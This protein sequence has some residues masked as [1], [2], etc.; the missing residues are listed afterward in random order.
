MKF[1]FSGGYCK[2]DTDRRCQVDMRSQPPAPSSSAERGLGGCC[3]Y[4][5]FLNVYPENSG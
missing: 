3:H 2:N 1:T 5:E 4:E